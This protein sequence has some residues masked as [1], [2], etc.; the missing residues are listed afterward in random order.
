MPEGQGGLSPSAA[1]N[2]VCFSKGHLNQEGSGR[3]REVTNTLTLE[4]RKELEIKMKKEHVLDREASSIQ[5]LSCLP[6]AAGASSEQTSSQKTG[7]VGLDGQSGYR[8]LNDSICSHVCLCTLCT[9]DAHRSQKR[10]SDSWS[11]SHHVGT[12]NRTWVL[13]VLNC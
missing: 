3:T 4:A 2:R 13:H 11:W 12:G 1:I 7:T 8:K 10:L 9:P 5:T 6:G